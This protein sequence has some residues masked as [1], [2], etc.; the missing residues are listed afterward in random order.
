MAQMT[1]SLDAVAQYIHDLIQAQCN[2]P[3]NTLKSNDG[4]VVLKAKN[5]FYGDQEKYPE[6]PAVAIE[7][8]DRPRTLAGLSYR[9]QNDF[10]VYILCYLAKVQTNQLTR[11]QIQ[12]ISEKIETLIHT[13]PQLGGLVVHGFCANNESGYVYR[14]GTLYRSNRIT[15]SGMS[16]TRLR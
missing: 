14:S 13:D 3:G 12:Q 2:L 5:V 15:Y 7:P 11:Q 4:A 6:S 9:S 10:G 1:D 8:S 16:K